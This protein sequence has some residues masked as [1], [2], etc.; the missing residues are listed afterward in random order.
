MQKHNYV[1]DE[2]VISSFSRLAHTGRFLRRV[3][4]GR[5]EET[6]AR[7]EG[8]GD[9]SSLVLNLGCREACNEGR[10]DGRFVYPRR[11]TH[12]VR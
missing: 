9:V 6:H 11:G 2:M 4:E 10:E 7:Q 1:L 8:N 3:G 12:G 5:G